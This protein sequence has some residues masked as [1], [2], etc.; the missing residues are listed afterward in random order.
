MAFVDTG[1]SAY[2]G[3]NPGAPSGSGVANAGANVG[4]SVSGGPGSSG[5]GSGMSIKS[6]TIAYLVLIIGILVVT[7]VLFNG[8]GKS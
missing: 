7:G 6:W 8:K 3:L 5:M 4:A 1:V 2:G